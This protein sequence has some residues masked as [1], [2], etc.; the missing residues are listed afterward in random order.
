MNFNFLPF[1]FKYCLNLSSEHTVVIRK[2]KFLMKH[3][4]AKYLKHTW[5]NRSVIICM[6]EM[7]SSW[8]SCITTSDK[9]YPNF[10]INQW[11]KFQKFK[12]SHNSQLLHFCVLNLPSCEA[13]LYSFS[14][15]S[16]LFLEKKYFHINTE[17]NLILE[18]NGD[19]YKRIRSAFQDCILGQL[20]HLQLHTEIARPEE[21]KQ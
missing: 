14:N 20:Q 11:K 17:I 5:S 4:P 2:L 10:R 18:M 6:L 3:I 15:S 8:N 9:L 19:K 21:R 13:I 16:S 12:N 7:S 1:F